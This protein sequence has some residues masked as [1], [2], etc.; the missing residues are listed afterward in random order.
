MS[1]K[2]VIATTRLSAEES[3]AISRLFDGRCSWWHW[4][5]DFWLVVDPSDSLTANSITDEIRSVAP[6]AQIFVAQVNN[7]LWSGYGPST[8]ERNMFS[9][10]RRIWE[11]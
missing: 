3:E 9:W 5:D 11:K 6:K 7:L 4:I 1:R 8:E 2:F 10:L